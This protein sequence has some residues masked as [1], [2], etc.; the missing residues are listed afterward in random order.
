ME[1]SCHMSHTAR[2]CSGIS[3][4]IESRIGTSHLVCLWVTHW[5]ES[6]CVFM[7]CVTMSRVNES[8]LTLR[9]ARTCSSIRAWGVC[10]LWAD[11]VAILFGCYTHLR[12]RLQVCV[13][14]CNLCVYA[15]VLL[16]VYTDHDSIQR[17]SRLKHIDVVN[18]TAAEFF[19]LHHTCVPPAFLIAAQLCAARCR[20]S[21]GKI[22][23]LQAKWCQEKQWR[24]V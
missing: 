5:N 6:F 15:N 14:V 13:C 23:Y 24:V 20:K 16:Y 18:S 19:Q 17:S 7:S 2:T 3:R 11:G 8:L 9:T 12:R 1:K 21:G 4:R 10:W 22:T